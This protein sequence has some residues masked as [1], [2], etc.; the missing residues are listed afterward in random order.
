[1]AVAGLRGSGSFSA[2]ERPQN[3]R[4]VLALQNPNT[5][6]PLVAL[7]GAM[8]SMP[9]DDP[10]FH[11]FT[12]ALPVQRA[13]VASGIDDTATTVTLNGT[14]SHLIFKAG[15]SI[16]NEQTGEV[17]WVT[18][19][20]AP[21]T[22]TIVR[23]RGSTAANIATNAGL[24]ILGPHYAEGAPV[25]TAISYDPVVVTNYT[26]IFRTVVDL[27]GTAQAT[28][29]RYAD[30]PMVEL[31][32]ESLEI[33]AIEMEKQFFFGSGVEDLSGSQPERT[34]RGLFF[35]IT[36][37]VSDFLDA[38]TIGDWEAYLENVFEDGT[39]EK[40]H[41]VGNRQ[42]TTLNAAARNYAE[43]NINPRS[44]AFGMQILTWITPYGTLALKQH[45]LFS[46]NPTFN[47]WGFTV[48]MTKVHYRHLRGRDT[49][50]LR[51]RQSPG[52]DATKDEF[53]TEAGLEIDFEQYHGVGTNASAFS[54]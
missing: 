7:T 13:T 1:M 12:K 34:T 17:M 20:P 24:V 47:D 9:T 5:E 32:R 45:P 42:L 50:Y 49:K 28:R 2:A 15:H 52:D 40:I 10:N 22:L 21:E 11:C 44:D 14:G 30:N 54:A 25:P 48:D 38:M 3:Y 16:M 31:K 29:L 33:H 43:I 36:T 46:K 37:N 23:G 27:T 53:L 39:N 6:A 8:P 18:G 4:G 19:S 41:F 35:F 26:Q 51:N